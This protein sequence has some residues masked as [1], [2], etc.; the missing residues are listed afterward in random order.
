ML[1]EHEY[2]DLGIIDRPYDLVRILGPRGHISRR[3]PAPDPLPLE[4]L[5]HRICSRRIL[6]RIAN[7]YV[8]VRGCPIGGV[9]GH[10]GK[11]ILRRKRLV[12]RVTFQ[13][14]EQRVALDDVKILIP[15]I[16]RSV[17][18]L[19]STIFSPRKANTRAISDGHEVP[20]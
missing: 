20:L 15:Q 5:D 3:D 13:I 11:F 7:E 6:R 2:E 10:S 4:S 1:R 14:L 17:Q 12:A 16:K 8:P 19:E 9:L 18:P